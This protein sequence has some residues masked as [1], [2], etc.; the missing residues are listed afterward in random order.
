MNSRLAWLGGLLGILATSCGGGSSGYATMGML[1]SPS[2]AV[3]GTNLVFAN[4]A[5][6]GTPE[7]QAGLAFGML[8]DTGSPVVLIDPSFFN[9]PGPATNADITGNINLGLVD[10]SGA[11]VLTLDNI[12]ALKLSDAMMTS[13]GFGGI[14][15]GN[16]MRQFSVQLNYADPMDAF[17][18]GDSG[19]EPDGVETPGAAIPFTLKSGGTATVAL[20]DK[21]MSPAVTIPPTRIALTLNIDGTDAAHQFHF[22]LDTG[23][24]EVSVRGSVYD[25]LIADGRPQLPGFQITTVLGGSNAAVTRARTITIGGETVTNVPVMTIMNAPGDPPDA[26]LDEIGGELGYQLDGLLGGSF[27]RNFLVTIDYPHGQLHLQRYAT[28]TWVDEFQRVGIGLGGTPLTS[29]HYYNAGVVYPGTDAA[30][31]GILVGD[32]IVSIDGTQ[33]DQPLDPITADNLLNGTVGT[34]KAIGLG[35]THA[36]AL[37]NTTVNVLVDDLIP[38][39]P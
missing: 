7:V 1:G 26:L 2:S 19:M 38:N 4:A 29:Q 33:L 11:I 23:A 6:N 22:L 32:E 5:L 13:L 25:M 16:V 24:S 27:L 15:G 21:V 34:T 39:P 20:S 12:P 30:N 18:L 36:A 17:R 9:M 28:E 35:M 8:I 37:T 14:L 31:Q 10:K 3:V